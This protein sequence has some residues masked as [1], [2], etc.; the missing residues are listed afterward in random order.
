MFMTV[1]KILSSMRQITCLF[2]FKVTEVTSRGIE[3]INTSL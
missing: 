1:Y 3:L 2:L